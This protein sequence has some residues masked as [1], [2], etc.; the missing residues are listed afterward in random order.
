M[1]RLTSRLIYI[2]KLAIL[3]NKIIE[4]T[5]PFSAASLVQHTHRLNCQIEKKWNRSFTLA[6]NSTQ[7]VGRHRMLS[8]VLHAL[9]KKYRFS[10]Y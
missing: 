6:V 2:S 4:D 9:L 8:L 7:P 10:C 5:I 3:G 1:D